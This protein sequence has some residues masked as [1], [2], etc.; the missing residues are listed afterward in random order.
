MIHV[1][2]SRLRLSSR[3]KRGLSNSEE[4]VWERISTS[5]LKL[6]YLQRKQ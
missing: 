6:A 1:G 3:A 4:Q 2:D 5:D